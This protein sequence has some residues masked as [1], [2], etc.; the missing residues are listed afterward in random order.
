MNV[1]DNNF[2]LLSKLLDL[3]SAKNKVLANNI[4]NANTPGFKKFEVSFQ[5]ELQKAIE[6]KDAEKM[7]NLKE[8]ITLSR[9]KSTTQDG[10][11]VDLEKELVTFY[12]MT[13]RYNIYVEL[14]S[15]KFKGIISAI[16]GR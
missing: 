7:K 12:Q 1:S 4:A 2:V 11:N 10:N 15:K 3:T 8:S 13:D 9:D 16:E 14:L 6:S 5:D